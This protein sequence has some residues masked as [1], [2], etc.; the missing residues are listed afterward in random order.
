MTDHVVL[1]HGAWHGA[2]CWEPVIPHLEQ[3]GLTVHT[4]DLPSSG[5]GGTLADDAEAVRAAV[6]AVGDQVVLVGHSYGGMAI[7]EASAGAATVDHLVY[8]TAFLLPAGLSLLD[9]VGGTAPPWWIVDENAGTVG[10]TDP[11]AV[12]FED[13]DEPTRNAAVARLSPQSLASFQGRLTGAGWTEHPS[14]YVVGEVDA[15]IPPVAQEAMSASAGTVRRLATGHSPFLVR[16]AELAELIAE[17]A[18]RGGAQ[19]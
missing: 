5:S 9:A 4:V 3:H 8:V 7:S 18:G 17:A 10:V 19:A 1:V 2:W 12:F 14:T 13:V 6:A 16:P 11:V 15:A